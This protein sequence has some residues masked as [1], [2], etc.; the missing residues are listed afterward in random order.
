V[1]ALTRLAGV[2]LAAAAVAACGASSS[3]DGAGATTAAASASAP[4]AAADPCAPGASAPPSRVS[5]APLDTVLRVP[6]RAR[7]HR[8]PL[9]LA[10]HFASGTGPEME[11]ATRLTPE[12]RRDGFVVAYPSASEGNFW[13][14]SG[15]FAKVMRTVDAIERVAC[16]DRSRVYAVGISNG[17]FMSTVLAC[18]AADRIAAVTLFAPGINGVG[19]CSPGRAPSVLEIH[20][21]ADPIV[22]YRDSSGRPDADIPAFIGAWARRDGCAATSRPQRVSA[23]V[24]RF[25]WPGCRAGARVEHLRLTGGRHIELLP[26]LRDAGVDPARTAWTFLS[27]H[28]LRRAERAAR[29]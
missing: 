17:G 16:V 15:D 24:T 14:A 23:T 6:A 19:D 7:G 9:V 5:G 20:G 13:S 25:R 4:A 2:L 29:T 11:Q 3:G 1:R 27:A 22:P 28:R 8:A 26:Q 21:T 10:L 18:R 12:A